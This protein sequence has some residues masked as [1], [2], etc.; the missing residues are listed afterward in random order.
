MNQEFVN[1]YVKCYERLRNKTVLVGSQEKKQDDFRE[2]LTT[3]NAV[4]YL[5][6]GSLRLR[7]CRYCLNITS[8]L[9]EFDEV[10]TLAVDGALHE[11]TIRDIVASFHP[12]KVADDAN[13]PN[14]ICNE[15]VNRAISCYLFTQQCDRAER[16]LRNC[17]DDIYDKFEKLDSL[18]PI[19]RRGKRKLHPNPN[20]IYAE[21]EEVIDYAEPVINI[22]NVTNQCTVPSNTMSE[23]E[24]QKCWQVLP[25]VESL[26]NH[27]NSHPKS[28]W[29]NCRL[30]GKSFVKRSLL[31]KHIKHTHKQNKETIDEYNDENFKCVVCGTENKSLTEHLQHNENHKFSS[32]V[33]S[34]LQR[35][36]DT[37]CTVCLDRSS[38]LMNM[39]DVVHLHGG[40]SGSM[41]DKSI[42]NILTATIPDPRKYKYEELLI[43]RKAEIVKLTKRIKKNK[44]M[45]LNSQE[46]NDN[47]AFSPPILLYKADVGFTSSITFR[48]SKPE[49]GSNKIR[50]LECETND[51]HATVC[52]MSIEEQKT[53]IKSKFLSEFA[54]PIVVNRSDFPDNGK[55]ITFVF[56]NPGHPSELEVRESDVHE[57]EILVDDFHIK[58]NSSDILLKDE[59]IITD[60]S[61]ISSCKICWIFKTATCNNCLK[62]SIPISQDEKYNYFTKKYDCKHCWVFDK[63]GKCGHCTKLDCKKKLDTEIDVVLDVNGAGNEL[64]G[65]PPITDAKV[66][67]MWQCN[68]CLSNNDKNR[69]TCICCDEEKV[70]KENV[71]TSFKERNIFR[72]EIRN[73]T[74][75]SSIK[76]CPKSQNITKENT[77]YKDVIDE[78]LEILNSDTEN[79]F[80]CV[81]E[82]DSIINT[83]NLP[84]NTNNNL[85]H[86]AKIEHLG[87]DSKMDIEITYLNNNY[88]I[89]EEINEYNNNISKIEHMDTSEYQPPKS[90]LDFSS[91]QGLSNIN[92]GV[93]TYQN[94]SQYTFSIGKG[95]SKEYKNR[96]TKR[97]SRRLVSYK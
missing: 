78:T 53:T 14:K 38:H 66:Q 94:A 83:D 43:P 31:R 36:V 23:L 71:F 46:T 97:A 74:I 62:N 6:Q 41:G 52:E 68:V 93:G 7:V 51:S 30:C 60:K 77:I 44:N 4:K 47:F 21:H 61:R 95:N 88:K 86:I 26:L 58:I 11:V 3:K 85:I 16:A 13:F 87:D 89:V 81:K 1:K 39:N 17:F 69:S 5:L 92:T 96:P 49:Q 80:P 29:Y 84:D 20:I 91:I 55:F 32:L 40:Y 63:A 70:K 15:C 24:C 12:Y 45:E 18:E 8:R 37:L 42:Q 9:S 28:M 59:Q 72:T 19:K 25:N 82:C 27:E 2:P 50:I 79:N 90:N 65:K 57:R 33:K 67:K 34:L 56:S 10:L 64:S 22:V 54:S 76:G 75:D 48:F 73:F 35:K